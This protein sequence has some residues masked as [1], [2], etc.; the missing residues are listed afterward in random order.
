LVIVNRGNAKGSD[1][2]SVAEQ[3]QNDVQAKFGITLEKEV[4]I[5]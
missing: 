3:I 4:N 2:L 1:I 5:W